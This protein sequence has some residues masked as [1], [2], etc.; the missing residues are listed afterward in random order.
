MKKRLI[1]ASLLV[2]LATSMSGEPTKTYYVYFLKFARKNA[3]KTGFTEAEKAVL[4]EHSRYHAR[5]AK[6]GTEIVGGPTLDADPT[7]IAIIKA[8]SIEEAKEIMNADPTVA[9]RVMKATLHPF[10]FAYGVCK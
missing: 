2:A 7:G 9:K 6:E 5:L 8:S 4:A 1:V 10:E 3:I